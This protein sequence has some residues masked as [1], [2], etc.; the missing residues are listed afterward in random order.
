MVVLRLLLLLLGC[1]LRCTGRIR[2]KPLAVAK[3]DP[4]HVRRTE[5]VP[6]Y[7]RRAKIEIFVQIVIEYRIQI[8]EIAFESAAQRFLY[9]WRC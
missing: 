1:R 3:L 6:R 2:S 5:T 9:G 4:V 7:A 8:D